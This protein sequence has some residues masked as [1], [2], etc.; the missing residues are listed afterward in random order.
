[1]KHLGLWS[2]GLQRFFEKL[3]KPS[4]P[5]PTYLMYAPLVHEEFIN[6][7]EIFSLTYGIIPLPLL[8]L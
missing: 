1:M 2:P 5:P 8:F 6:F 4:R 3:V 7:E